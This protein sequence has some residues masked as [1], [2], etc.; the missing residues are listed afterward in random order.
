MSNLFFQKILLE[1]KE[2]LLREKVVKFNSLMRL[3][4]WTRTKGILFRLKVVFAILGNIL[5]WLGAWNLELYDCALSPHL[6][7][8]IQHH[9]A[10]KPTEKPTLQPS[11]FLVNPNDYQNR[12]DVA[13]EM[14][15]R[16]HTNGEEVFL[17]NN[18]DNI[19]MRSVPIHPHH[20][21]YLMND[22][23]DRSLIICGCGFVL[24]IITDTLYG[25]AGL[26]G[27][28]I[29]ACHKTPHSTGGYLGSI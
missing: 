18:N 17:N 29:K 14:R 24:L 27:G 10:S 19:D 22:A 20:R 11:S 6:P 4:C 1:E 13:D 2:E 21:K 8:C 3:G 25:N 9:P 28:F 15:H 16:R 7:A 12:Q 5:F 26:E 23:V